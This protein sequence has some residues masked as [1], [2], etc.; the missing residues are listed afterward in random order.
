MI[1]N[2][3]SPITIVEIEAASTIIISMIRSSFNS[4]SILILSIASRIIAPALITK[5]SSIGTF[6]TNLLISS[7][8]PVDVKKNITKAA[9]TIIPRSVTAAAALLYS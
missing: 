2:I 1:S 8:L 7:F 6:A 4:S 9:I 3:R 5:H